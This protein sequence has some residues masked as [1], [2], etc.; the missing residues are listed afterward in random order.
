[1]K[2]TQNLL[3]LM[4]LS[5]AL[6]AFITPKEVKAIGEPKIQS[7]TI[8]Q[9]NTVLTKE[10][11]Y[12]IAPGYDN[13]EVSY[14][15]VNA[16]YGYGSYY[17]EVLDGSEYPIS[18][19]WYYPNFVSELWVNLNSMDNPIVTYEFNLCSDWDCETI[20]DTRTISVNFTKFGTFDDDSI[21][22]TKVMQGG[23]EI[24]LD[25]NQGGYL[26]NNLQDV[27]FSLKGENLDSDGTY[28]IECANKS[29][30]YTGD[31]LMNGVD[32]TCIV[33]DYQ[34]DS[35]NLNYSI[36]RSGWSIGYFLEE[37]DIITYPTFYLNSDNNIKPFEST[38]KYTNYSKELSRIDDDYWGE[39]Y[40]YLVLSKYLNTTDTM[41]YNIKGTDFENKN[42]TVKL[43]ILKGNEN[44]YTRSLTV[45]G[46][47]LNSGYDAEFTN[48]NP[49]TVS[50]VRYLFRV[51]I[52][53]VTAETDIEYVY[54]N[55][56][57]VIKKITQGYNETA[58]PIS[59]GT[60]IADGYDGIYI[61][62]NIT[63]YQ[64]EDELYIKLANGTYSYIPGNP[65]DLSLDQFEQEIDTFTIRLCAD[66][67]CNKIYT[68]DD[69]KIQFTHYNQVK[70][71][72]IYF[73]NVKQAGNTINMDDTGTFNFNDKQLI[74][75]MVKGENLI[76]DATYT[77]RFGDKDLNVLGS[78]ITNGV[79]LTANPQNS[80]WLSTYFKLGDVTLNELYY[81]GTTYHE[82]GCNEYCVF[83]NFNTENQYNKNYTATLKY[84]N[85]P[86]NQIEVDESD[87]NSFYMINSKYHNDG[88][89]LMYY[90]KG[91]GYEN[92]NYT[93]NVKISVDGETII[94]NRDFTVNGNNLNNGTNIDLTDLVLPLSTNIEEIMSGEYGMH[95]LA[96]NYSSKMAKRI[97]QSLEDL[98]I[99][100]CMTPIKMFSKNILKYILTF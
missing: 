42:Y 7:I 33:S 41:T 78:E 25:N 21:Y 75:M 64:Q 18:S 77:L 32:H 46:N 35:F 31:E 4:F 100:V 13:L 84:K 44:V 60:Y 14:G 88:N 87:W 1:M 24:T 29:M 98:V 27:V 72:R 90:V 8:K 63:N 67:E 97:Y 38:L 10:G 23:V 94:Y 91:T 70:N 68:F 2:K 66:S 47:D 50:N 99:V 89:P 61:Y 74:S 79:E 96:L 71:Q 58:L 37:E 52:D 65:L 48:F 57:L 20:Y 51:T 45:S 80:G 40:H 12:Y 86:S 3:F 81:D 5:L 17:L 69:I 43:T 55:I 15:L 9:G 95:M 28:E 11:N 85:Y 76:N 73:Y 53:D 16:G 26:F 6:F 34:Y 39:K 49:G 62:F 19:G 30:Y 59:N 22:Y 92:K 54:S 83:F 82:E 56:E 36:A 93:V